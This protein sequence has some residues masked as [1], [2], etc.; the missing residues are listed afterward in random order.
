M[1]DAM[2]GAE[3]RQVIVPVADVEAALRFYRDVLGLTVKF[4]DGAR[5]AA[6]DLG[7]ITLGLAGPEEH[8]AGTGIALGIKVADIETAQT[9]FEA[10]DGAQVDPPV[11]GPHE[12]RAMCRSAELNT[13]VL[14]QTRR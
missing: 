2:G 4:Q 3:L 5:W 10:L 7:G 6:L 12:L 13:L 1:T 9:A 14:Y 11:E 8:T